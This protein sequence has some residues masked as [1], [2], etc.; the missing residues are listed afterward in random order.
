MKM[1]SQIWSFQAAPYLSIFDN[2][3]RESTYDHQILKTKEKKIHKQSFVEFQTWFKLL[4]HFAVSFDRLRI[5]NIVSSL[6]INLLVHS[7]T[8]SGYTHRYWVY[9]TV[10]K[11][12]DVVYLKYARE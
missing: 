8:E 2:I 6:C 10:I 9:V 4:K 5:W 1:T 12:K 3:D 7:V 11:T